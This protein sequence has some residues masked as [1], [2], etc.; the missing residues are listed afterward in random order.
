MFK[1][2]RVL[3][4]NHGQE[5]LNELTNYCKR[6]NITSAIIL[7]MIGSLERADLGTAPKNGKYGQEHDEYT[8]HLSVLSS[9][10]SL[11]LYDGEMIFHIHMALID[12]H[13]PGQLIGGHLH[14]ATVWATIEI[15]IGELDYQLYREFDPVI[16]RAALRTSD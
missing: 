16:G 11:C 9:Q 12:P 4:L 14:G 3:R 15:Y 8:G 10:G 7:G 5:L 13:K 6:K 1:S 2:V